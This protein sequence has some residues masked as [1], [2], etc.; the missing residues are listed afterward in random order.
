MKQIRQYTLAAAVILML[1][2]L[3]G[4][5]A[6][7]QGLNRPASAPPK[8]LR[9]NEDSLITAATATSDTVAR[10]G[11]STTTALLFSMAIPG[12]GQIYNGAYWKPPIIWGVGYYFWSVYNNQ[13]KLYRQSRALYTA[14]ITTS[15][16]DGDALAKGN[17]NFYKHQRDTFG[18]YLAIAYI[19]NVLDAYVD[20]SLYSFEV[21]PNLQPK[22]DIQWMSLQVR[23]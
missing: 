3:A 9:L 17:R 7:A 19:V 14:S 12:A 20:A 2:P 21:S 23:F 4:L 10:Q 8:T 1:S 22:N 16:P 13:D 6:D 11:K 5:T 15:A 18:W